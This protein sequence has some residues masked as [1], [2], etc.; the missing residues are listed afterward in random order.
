M[1]RQTADAP[2]DRISDEARAL[3]G[4]SLADLRTRWREIWGDPPSFRSRDLM[5]RASVY[6]LQAEVHGGL[7]PPVRRRLAEYAEKFTA[8]RKFTPVSG[9]VLKPG[10][11]L[12]RE[13]GGA[14]HEVAVAAQGFIYLGE[15]YRSLSQVAQRITGTKWNGLVFFGV[16]PRAGKGA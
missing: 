16:K 2:S 10:S 8:D 3:T 9:P 13:W 14:R 15:P 7:P 11:S 6:R 12:I 5:L 1:A 4:L